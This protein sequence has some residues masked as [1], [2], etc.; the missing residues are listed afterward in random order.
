MHIRMY[1]LRDLRRRSAQRPLPELR[2]RTRDAPAAA[3]E[4]ACEIP[5]IDATHR[6]ARRLRGRVIAVGL[7]TTS[8][9][10]RA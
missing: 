6:E 8:R 4:P 9:F 10:A 1:F 7:V 5:A 2:R 3:G